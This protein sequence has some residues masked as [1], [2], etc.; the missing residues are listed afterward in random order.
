MATEVEVERLVTRLI[1]DATGLKKAVNEGIAHIK[2]YA[3]EAQASLAKARTA[4]KQSNSL[5][6][7]GARVAQSVRTPL[8]RYN[9]EMNNLR[10]LLSKGAI[11]QHTYQLA[12]KQANESIKAQMGL[13]RG[14]G[15]S[16]RE[17]GFA[18]TMVG[19][20]MTAIF[21]S[22]AAFS[23]RSAA[24]F[25]QTTIAF[26][27]ML[28]S[29]EAAQ[30]TLRD[31]TTFAVK[32]PFT[33]PQ[34]L[35]A[36]RGLVQF[37]ER[38][39]ELIETLNILGNAA[40]GT[41]T[42]FGM[43]A[44]IFNQIRGVGK[45]LTQDFR[46]LSTRAVLTLQDIADHFHIAKEE[47][48]A[49]LS[50]GKIS[51]EDVRNILKG[52]SS[53]GG[54][55]FD[56]LGKQSRS[57]TGLW[58]TLT[59][60]LDIA[61]RQLGEK[62]LPVAKDVV[63]AMIRLTDIV[64][65]LPPEVMALGAGVVGLGAALGVG[66]T[67]L[68]GWLLIWPQLTTVIA[69]A[70]IKLKGFVSL[71]GLAQ[72]GVLGIAGVVAYGTL[73]FYKY[74]TATEQMNQELKRYRDLSDELLQKDK[75]RFDA[76]MELALEWETAPERQ[77][78]LQASMKDARDEI[79]RLGKE[80]KAAKEAAQD[81]SGIFIKEKWNDP[82]TWG[83]D[84][85]LIIQE[86][87]KVLEARMG[88]AKQ[89]IEDTKKALDDLS[90]AGG[91][92]PE[93]RKSVDSYTASLRNQ[94]LTLR[95]GAE[96]AKLYQFSLLGVANAEI[97]AM[98]KAQG[99]VEQLKRGEKVKDIFKNMAL[100]L[101]RVGMTAEQ[102]QLDKLRMMEVGPEV[103]AMAERLLT[104][105]KRRKDHLDA[106]AEARRKAEQAAREAK[107]R[108]EA[109][110]RSLAER[111]K[112]IIEANKTA[113][114][115]ARDQV[116]ELNMLA[117]KGLIDRTTYFRAMKG[118][119]DDL[120]KLKEEAKVDLTFEFDESATIAGSVQWLRQLRKQASVLGS[121]S[122]DAGRAVPVPRGEMVAKESKEMATRR[123]EL[124]EKARQLKALEKIEKN[125][126]EGT[127][128]HGTRLVLPANLDS[129]A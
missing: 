81:F 63:S 82:S 84:A 103:L 128:G 65:N 30:Q 101:R 49:L 27:T 13:N 20:A 12:V 23:L 50:A 124:R 43:V 56:M 61:K 26:E 57:L 46:Q 25:E 41:S 35:Q 123:E 19:G 64:A 55:Y 93:A 42:D 67:A 5:F 1:G 48:Q 75:D 104:L 14:L 98:R 18:L 108:A 90:E 121:L 100:E 113:V 2:T 107:A 91:I 129:V 106:I 117:R 40:S 95:L 21:G 15:D 89:H 116:K 119:K 110:A 99:M 87:I 47:A 45:L 39:K 72:F 11:D 51:F 92:T 122:A 112:S 88:M 22:M 24:S 9:Q 114:E 34:I 38:G 58:S 109:E 28:G 115:K 31:L 77:L 6:V 74:I 118:I 78:V 85:F 96:E 76:A 54:R 73:Q 127:R 32:T 7:E 66:L 105:T 59:D 16:L 69:T 8:Q 94:I 86:R 44:L 70:T 68:G 62:L 33:M 4:A 53:E 10:F 111:A 3:K 17:V 83:G 97:E 80:L 37:G 125:T 36:A 71:A 126:R 120:A 29:A 52:L 102:I 60:A 79:D